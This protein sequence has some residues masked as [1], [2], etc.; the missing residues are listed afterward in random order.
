MI[1]SAL[2]RGAIRTKKETLAARVNSKGPK[3]EPMHS[4]PSYE[5]HL[6]TT[7]S[8]N[9]VA[10]CTSCIVVMYLV[11]GVLHNRDAT[12]QVPHTGHKRRPQT[13]SAC[14]YSAAR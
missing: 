5:Y 13:D 14:M 1:R 3:C 8:T 12:C 7:V 4:R 2:R 6:N 10:N 9:E 11:V